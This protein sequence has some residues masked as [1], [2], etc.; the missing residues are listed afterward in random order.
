MAEDAISIVARCEVRRRRYLAELCE[1][2]GLPLTPPSRDL[3]SHAAHSHFRSRPS[4]CSV[5]GRVGT[6]AVSLGQGAVSVGVAGAM[7]RQDLLLPS[8]RDNGTVLWR[9]GTS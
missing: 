3:W 5:T 1:L 8:Y 7:R 2:P 9:G 6:Y 4:P